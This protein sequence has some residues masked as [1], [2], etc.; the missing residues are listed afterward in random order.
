MRLKRRK[1]ARATA[2]RFMRGIQAV[3][4]ERAAELERLRADSADSNSSPKSNGW[5]M[6][7]DRAL[8]APR[9]TARA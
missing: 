4:R 8:E 1:K 3:A 7:V 6:N 2:C 9:E 5:L